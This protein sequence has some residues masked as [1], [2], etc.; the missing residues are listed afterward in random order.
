MKRKKTPLNRKRVLTDPVFELS[1]Q[2][3]A[4]FSRACTANRL[5]R[6]AFRLGMLNK[7]D[8]YV[9]GRLTKTMFKI[10]QSDPVNGRGERRVPKGVLSILEGFNFNRDT[11]LQNV[12]KAPYS[13]IINQE[14]MQATISI[15]SLIPRAMIDTASG[16][17][18]FLLTAM[19]AAV[20]L[21][22]EAFPVNPLQT[23]ILDLDLQ[24]HENLQLQL[25]II[26]PQP[27]DT[28]VVGLGIEFFLNER[29]SIEP[30]DKK[31]NALAVVKVF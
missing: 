11:S 22:N 14:A 25:P 18:A 10:L 17:N 13:I 3:S 26:E 30:L 15:P 12:L 21:E 7:A 4:E 31:H 24:R 8:R 28:V 9:S 27:N 1:R 16:A 19:A 6:Q 29:G 23:E 5:L 2:N 20:N